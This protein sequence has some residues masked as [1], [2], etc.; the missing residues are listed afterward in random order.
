M[1]LFRCTRCDVVENTALSNYWLTQLAAHKSAQ[2]H[3]P[4]C[5]QCDPDI[6]EWHEEFPRE[7]VSAE[8]YENPQGHLWR[9]HQLDSVKHMG[10][11]TP[12]QPL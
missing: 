5:S 6:G 9:K 3:E 12:V 1:P 10:P 8:W 11:F 2:P 7:A 4:L